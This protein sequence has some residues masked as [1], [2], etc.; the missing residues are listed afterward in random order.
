MRAA[1]TQEE[2]EASPP[3]HIDLRPIP[4]PEYTRTSIGGER[5]RQGRFDLQLRAE[6]PLASLKAANM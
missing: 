3:Q 2:Q 6:A 4:H 1:Q 5:V